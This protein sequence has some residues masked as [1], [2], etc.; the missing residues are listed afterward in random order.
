MVTT[1]AM[2]HYPLNEA[3]I[4][5]FR[6]WL[7]LRASTRAKRAWAKLRDFV[8]NFFPYFIRSTHPTL[9]ASYRHADAGETTSAPGP[10]EIFNNT[11]T[12]GSWGLRHPW[13]PPAFYFWD[14][15]NADHRW[16]KPRWPK[17]LAYYD[18]YEQPPRVG[19]LKRL[20]KS[21]RR[22]YQYPVGR[23]RWGRY[24]T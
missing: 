15:V 21:V 22:I 3:A 16:Y 19:P 17:W 18:D 12:G 13:T 24:V 8:R 23:D 10:Y 9:G 4:D 7:S 5:V 2:A 20:R 6:Q 14:W 1:R 11:A